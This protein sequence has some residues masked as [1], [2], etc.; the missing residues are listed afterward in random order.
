MLRKERKRHPKQ[1]DKC[2]EQYGV[3]GFGQKQVGHSLNVVD[4]PAALSHH[5]WQCREAVVKQYQLSHGPG[6]R[7]AGAHGDAHVGV[8]EGQ[9]VVH[10]V[11]RHSHR[12]AT[13]L[14]GPHHGLLLVGRD[15]T[16]HR[17]A[18]V[19]PSEGVG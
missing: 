12:P 1:A 2:G 9:Y 10:A 5:P 18:G 13:G 16:E 14:Q 7:T 19:A 3:G 8:F 11:A 17:W 15:P 6:G 4:D